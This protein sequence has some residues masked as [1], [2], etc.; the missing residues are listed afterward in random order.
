MTNIGQTCYMSTVLQTLHNREEVRGFVTDKNNFHFR[1][2]TGMTDSELFS[3]NMAT[4]ASQ[5]IRDA[6]EPR[7][8]EFAHPFHS[9]FGDDVCSDCSESIRYDS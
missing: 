3:S 7:T 2:Q 4:F 9:S 1:A 6:R 5:A 8:R